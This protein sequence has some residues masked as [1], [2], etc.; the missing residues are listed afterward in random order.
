MNAPPPTEIKYKFN[1]VYL[2]ASSFFVG[3][4]SNCSLTQPDDLTSDQT[5]LKRRVYVLLLSRTQPIGWSEH[6]LLLTRTQSS[7]WSDFTR[8]VVQVTATTKS[9]VSAEK[10]GVWVTNIFAKFCA[11]HED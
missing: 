9:I 8:S 5:A 1:T 7:G 2:F 4:G 3:A 10:G 6:S 11:E